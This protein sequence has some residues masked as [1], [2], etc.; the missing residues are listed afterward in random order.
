MEVCSAA[1]LARNRTIAD[2]SLLSGLCLTTLMKLIA[3]VGLGL[4]AYLIY[5]VKQ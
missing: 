4:L 3:D 1:R 5:F 2:S